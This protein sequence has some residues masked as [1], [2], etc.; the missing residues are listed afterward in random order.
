MTDRPPAEF[1]R[2]EWEAAVGW[3]TPDLRRNKASNFTSAGA[4]ARQVAIILAMPTH[5][6]LHRVLHGTVD[7]WEPVDLADLPAP[8]AAEPEP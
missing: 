6:R 5:L 7:R 1:W 4:A 8:P 3:P 2:V